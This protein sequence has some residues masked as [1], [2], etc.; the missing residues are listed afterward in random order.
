MQ[1]KGIAKPTCLVDCDMH[2]HYSSTL[3]QKNSLS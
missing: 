2:S 1:N 3:L